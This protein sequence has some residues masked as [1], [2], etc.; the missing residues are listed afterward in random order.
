M[1]QI[2]YVRLSYEDRASEEVPI[3]VNYNADFSKNSNRKRLLN[4][5]LKQT[6]NVTE[7]KL[8]F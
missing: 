5:L 3:H 7:V 1:T 6:P 2:V 4:R 8:L